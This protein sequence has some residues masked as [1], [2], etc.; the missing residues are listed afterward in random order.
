MNI[1][2][3]TERIG[4]DNAVGD[5]ITNGFAHFLHNISVNRV[6]YDKIYDH[7]SPS[8]KSNDK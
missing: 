5:I 6:P 2:R 1:N 7:L 3:I 4:T 8:N